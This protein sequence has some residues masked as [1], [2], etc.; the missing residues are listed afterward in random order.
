M[1]FSSSR[2][3]FDFAKHALT[4]KYV[5]LQMKQSSKKPTEHG[6]FFPIPVRK[7]IIQSIAARS[8]PHFFGTR[9]HTIDVC[10]PS[11]RCFSVCTSNILP[12]VEREC[13]LTRL[14]VSV[15]MKFGYEKTDGL[16]IAVSEVQSGWH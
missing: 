16:V 6:D 9:R 14:N 8:W 3:F 7:M 13:R 5:R 2:G 10:P 15:K 12:K 1:K 11:L 4:C